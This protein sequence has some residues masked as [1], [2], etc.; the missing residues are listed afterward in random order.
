MPVHVHSMTSEITAADANL[1]L[2]EQQIDALVRIILQRL[3]RKKRDDR[4][5]REATTIRPSARPRG[6]AWE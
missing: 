5:T 1:P 4:E 6:D 2:T 3:E